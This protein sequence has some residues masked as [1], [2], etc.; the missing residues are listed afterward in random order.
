M[1]RDNVKWAGRRR[2]QENVAD[3]HTM[4]SLL[5][6]LFNK[7]LLQLDWLDYNRQRAESIGQHT[8]VNE[9]EHNLAGF[10]NIIP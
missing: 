1:V 5:L 8:V 9:E 4:L 6:L 3:E 2:S 7:R 10:C